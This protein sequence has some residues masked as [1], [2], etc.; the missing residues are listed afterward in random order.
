[1]GLIDWIHKDIYSDINRF[2]ESGGPCT[3]QGGFY[4]GNEVAINKL[5]N[6]AYNILADHINKNLNSIIENWVATVNLLHDAVA[7]PIGDIAAFIRG[8]SKGVKFF[9]DNGREIKNQ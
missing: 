7:E 6:L 3:V 4:F 1:M 2:Y 8:L 9:F 5:N